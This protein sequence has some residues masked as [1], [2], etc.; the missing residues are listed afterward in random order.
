VYY[1]ER[2]ATYDT[3][4]DVPEFAE[5]LTHLKGW[6]IENAR[7]QTILE[8]A[9]GTGYW[10]EA[11]A[12]VAKAITATDYNPEVLAIASG[13]RLGS[14]VTL[15]KADAY[16][17][18]DFA[19]RF[20]MGMAH[21]WWSHVDKAKQQTFL[22]EFTS[23]LKPGATIL[24]IDQLYSRSFCAPAWRRDRRGNRFELRTLADGTDYEILKNYP[25]PEAV[26]DSLAVVCEDISVLKLRYFWA[27]RARI[28]AHVDGPQSS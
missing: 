9:A 20:D 2:A 27:L 22:A 3:F 12:S 23:H 6:L 18:P 7:D 25:R 1:R 17:L 16:A 28:H 11:A 4:Y 8:V 10:T 5:E 13:R 15:L 26:S 19:P 21:L 14:H 24:M